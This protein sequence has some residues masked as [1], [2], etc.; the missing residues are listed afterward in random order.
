MIVGFLAS[1]LIIRR[2]KLSPRQCVYMSMTV[3]AV[4]TL[5]FVGMFFF[6]CPVPP[7]AGVTIPYGYSP[8][9]PNAPQL[10]AEDANLLSPCNGECSCSTEKYSPVCGMDGVTYFSACHAGC[11]EGG[12]D[13]VHPMGFTLKKYSNCGCLAKLPP[14]VLM[15][16]AAKFSGGGGKGPGGRPSAN[17]GAGMPGGQR[18]G[19]GAGIP[20]SGGQRPGTGAGRPDS[21]GQRPGTGAGMPDSGGQRPGNGT[22]IPDSSG[23]RPGTGAGM[24][25]SGGQRPGNGTGM[26]DSSGQRPGTGAGMPDSGGQRPA[27]GEGMPDSGG[28]RPGT[29]D[30]AGIPDSG[31]QRP[32]PGAGMPDSGDQSPNTGAGMPDPA[33]QGSGTADGMPDSGDVRPG[34]GAG[35]PGSG[36]RR[37]GTGVPGKGPMM[38][39]GMKMPSF[40]IGAPCPQICGQWKYF[41]GSFV[42]VG[43]LSSFGLIPSIIA[44]LRSLTP[45]TKSLGMGVQIVFYRL[46]GFIPSPIYFGVLIDSTCRLWNTTCGERGACLLYDLDLNRYYFLGLMVAFRVLSILCEFVAAQRFKRREE[47]EPEG[48]KEVVTTNDIAS[49]LGNLAGSIKSLDMAGRDENGTMKDTEDLRMN[50][51]KKRGGEEAKPLA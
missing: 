23:Q 12:E 16:I 13:F 37:P 31:G 48:K 2:F 28:K 25:D 42:V 35:M 27:N 38:P 47:L 19:T 1:G 20:G 8:Y 17:G 44:V 4:S 3:T 39:P 33:G 5:G 51:W 30:G 6:T 21:G 36:G 41:L 40:A 9:M 26:P 22:G 24:P 29:G 7:M 15:K 11:T 14:E 49:S 46:L 10:A 50:I 45:E 43:F 18:P 32:T 34:N